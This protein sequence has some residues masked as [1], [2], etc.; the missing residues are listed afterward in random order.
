MQKLAVGLGS[1]TIRPLLK[2]M[3]PGGWI[4]D[5]AAFPGGEIG[6]VHAR[7][8]KAVALA[9]TGAGPGLLRLSNGDVVAWAGLP[10]ADGRKVTLTAARDLPKLAPGLDGMFA[11]IGWSAQDRRLY[12]I[13]DFLGLQP[14]YV[15]H[16]FAGGWVAASETKVF[17]YEP[18]PA[19]WGGFIA[20]G[21]TIGSVTLTQAARRLRP[22]SVLT[23]TP[24]GTPD[25]KPRIQTACHWRMPDEG[26]EPPL[27]EVVAA[28]EASTAAYQALAGENLCL[29][30]GGFDSR[31]IL[32]LLH[33]LNGRGE[34]GRGLRAFTLS[35]HDQDADMDGLIAARV[36]RH[37]GTPLHYFRH[38]RDFFSTAAYL[39][40]VWAI[41]AATPNMHLFI[42]QLASTLQD[43]GAVWEGVLPAIALRSPLQTGDG[44]F[45]TLYRSKKKVNPTAIRIFKPEVRKA[46]LDAFEQ[47]FAYTRSFF[48]ETPHGVW[49]WVIEHRV[50]NRSGVNPTKVYPNHAATLLLGSSRRVWEL[51]ASVGYERRK[52]Y[53]YY[54]DV[55]RAVAPDMARIPFYSEGTLHRAD[56]GWIDYTACRLGQ[57]A[58]RA[59]AGRP[60]LARACGVHRKFGF[61]PSRFVR[62]P[63][64]FQ[65]EDDML[66][67]DFVRR[68]ESDDQLRAQ[69]GKLL[70]HWRA[71]RW[72]HEDRLHATL[73]PA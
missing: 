46:F 27:Q 12:I 7:P 54:I 42:A 2:T 41:D 15:G 21:H 19:G 52:Q 33:R 22:A 14:V 48:P 70:F 62:H 4:I 44:G 69:A 6:V 1:Q 58:W 39:D 17:P 45:D 51:V 40:Y 34:E 55:F 36:A 38:D 13:T 18:D 67:M 30:S 10:L 25:A 3:D 60:F 32:G 5:T 43:K 56:A 31:L 16:D 8:D 9:R 11:A 66:D 65:E 23:V 28:L 73:L 24:P 37:T 53:R 71:A 61:I 35:N 47:E 63:A 57:K 64:I 72:L 50:R 20:F 49:Q 29:L 68:I 59:L 26:R